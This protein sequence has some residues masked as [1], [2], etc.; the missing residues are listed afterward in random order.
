MSTKTVAIVGG[1]IAGLT[2]ALCFARKGISSHIFEKSPQLEEVGAG[3][4]LTPNVTCILRDL[5]LLP[6][7][8]NCWLEP[9]VV[10]LASG[11]SLKRLGTVPVRARAEHHW[12]A[13]YAVLHRASLQKVLLNAVMQNPLCTLTLGQNVESPDAQVLRTACSGERPDLLIAADGVW[14]RLR[15]FVSG[16]PDVSFSGNIAWRLTI[17]ETSAPAFIDRSAVTAYLAPDAHLVTYPLRDSKSINIVA[18]GNGVDPVEGWAS[19]VSAPNYTLLEKSFRGWHST[20]RNMLL[21]AQNITFWPLFEAG[22][23]RWHNGK[24]LVLIGDAAHAMM[25]FSAQGAGM[26]IEDAFELANFA[27]KMPPEQALQ[28]FETQRQQRIN[29]V[30][31]R[32]SLNKFAYHASGPARL[33]RDI[34][35]SLRSPASFARDLDWLYGYRA[36]L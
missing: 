16:G 8:Q 18:I 13:P 1:G 31:K 2:A 9:E 22:V 36:P 7:L 5:G 29:M 15:N 17:P 12:G 14:S 10:A 19:H 27:T 32:G 6:A 34:L 28:Q 4:Q 35:L 23:G 3:L 21:T 30:R 20:V 33:G 24:D 25:P 11:S 26:A